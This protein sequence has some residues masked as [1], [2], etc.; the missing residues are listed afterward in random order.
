MA[1]FRARVFPGAI[2]LITGPTVEPTA[3]VAFLTTRPTF[4]P[5]SSTFATTEPSEIYGARANIASSLV[6]AAAR[7][8]DWATVNPPRRPKPLPML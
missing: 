1:V 7:A 6:V 5:S 3:D 4:V 8:F 2:L